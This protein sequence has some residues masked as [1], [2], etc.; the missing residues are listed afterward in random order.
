VREDGAMKK[1]V[2]R[3]GGWRKEEQRMRRVRAGKRRVRE[4]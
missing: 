2:R 3:E 1:G 4:E